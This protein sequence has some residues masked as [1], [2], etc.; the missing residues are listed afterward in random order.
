MGIRGLMAFRDSRIIPAPPWH[1]STD[2]HLTSIVHML[3][4]PTAYSSVGPS[5]LRP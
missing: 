2:G 4:K 5:A 1:R 3:I